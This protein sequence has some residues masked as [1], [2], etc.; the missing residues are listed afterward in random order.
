MN[1]LFQTQYQ[2]SAACSCVFWQM[3]SFRSAVLQ[4]V[5]VNFH[6]KLLDRAE[7]HVCSSTGPLVQSQDPRVCQRQRQ[8]P[9]YLEARQISVV[10]GSVLGFFV[11]WKPQNWIFRLV[12]STSRAITCQSLFKKVTEVSDYLLNQGWLCPWREINL[13]Y[14]ENSCCFASPFARGSPWGNCALLGFL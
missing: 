9:K 8:I 10:W 13:V 6:T 1:R 4:V 11:M 2:T 12:Q 14:C 5:P 3:T 7:S